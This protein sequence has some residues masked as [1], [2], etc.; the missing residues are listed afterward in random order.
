M[1]LWPYFIIVWRGVQCDYPFFLQAEQSHLECL[2]SPPADQEARTLVIY[3]NVGCSTS[4][5]LCS[6]DDVAQRGPR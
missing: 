2:L 5:Q 3:M 6:S 4:S 1:L